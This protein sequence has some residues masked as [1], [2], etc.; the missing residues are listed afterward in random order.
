[1]GEIFTGYING[2][3][4]PV[5]AKGR[6]T[7]Q[8]NGDI[9]SWLSTGIKALEVQI[10]LKSPNPINPIKGITIN[11]LSLVYDAAMPYNPTLSCKLS[12]VSFESVMKA[13]MQPRKA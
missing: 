10:P 9:I 2:E 3:S 4:V 13:A 8:E 12:L 1:M 5:Q 7:Q 6:S 11:Y